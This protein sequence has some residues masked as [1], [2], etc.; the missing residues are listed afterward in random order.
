VRTPGHPVTTVVF[1]SAFFIIALSTIIQFPHSAGIGVLILLAGV[2]VYLAWRRGS[3]R[4]FAR[5][6][7]QRRR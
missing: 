5:V 1:V 6:E 2:P 3:D 7:S 4:L